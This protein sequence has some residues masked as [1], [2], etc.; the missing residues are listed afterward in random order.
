MGRCRFKHCPYRLRNHPAL[1][2]SVQLHLDR[3]KKDLFESILIVRLPIL[4]RHSERVTFNATIFPRQ[5]CE[6]F[7]LGVCCLEH[8][9]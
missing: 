4:F 8:T 3:I 5:C 7:T 2:V 9:P 6:E 1:H